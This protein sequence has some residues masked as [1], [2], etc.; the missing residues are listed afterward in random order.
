[1]AHNESK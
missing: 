1:M